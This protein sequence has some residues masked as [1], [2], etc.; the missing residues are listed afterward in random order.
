MV[1][2]MTGGSIVGGYV[3]SRV[4]QRVSDR[5]VRIAIVAIG[6]AM[7]VWLTVSAIRSRTM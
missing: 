3:S 7:A 4:A 6:V 5:S 1:L 2:V